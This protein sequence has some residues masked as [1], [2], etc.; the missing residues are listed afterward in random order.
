MKPNEIRSK[1]PKEIVKTIEEK[2]K[3]VFDLRLKKATGQLADVSSIG[4][5]KKDIARMLTILTEKG[6]K[7]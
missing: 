5:N 4:K 1:E 7:T 3:E 6:S 2:R